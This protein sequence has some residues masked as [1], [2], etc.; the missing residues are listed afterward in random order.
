MTF[1]LDLQIL[2]R[3]TN[4]FLV[5]FPAANPPVSQDLQGSWPQCGTWVLVV[6]PHNRA[7]EE[8]QKSKLP[9]GH[10]SPLCSAHPEGSAPALTKT[11][12]KELCHVNLHKAYFLGQAWNQN[13]FKEDE[14]LNT[15]C[16]GEKI[17]LQRL[18]L[19]HDTATNICFR[20]SFS[21]C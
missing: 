11:I 8:V 15:C 5:W 4:L 2:G 14:T 20:F 16:R 1:V 18:Y 21:F 9:P 12:S 7:V 3:Q 13:S 6:L 10:G 17:T 19:T